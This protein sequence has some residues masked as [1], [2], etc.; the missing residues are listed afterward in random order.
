MTFD[1][2]NGCEHL[3]QRVIRFR[4]GPLARAPADSRPPG[5][6]Y[7]VAGQGELQLD[8]KRYPLGPR[9]ASSSPPAKAYAVENPGPEPSSSCQSPPTAELA[10]DGERRKVTVRFDDQAELHGV[11]RAHLPLP[12]QRGRGLRRRDPVRRDR[13]AE[14]GAHAQP[15]VRRGRATSS[16]ARESP[17]WEAGRRRL[18]RARASTCR[19]TRVHCIENSGPGRDADSRGLPPVRQPGES[20][21]YEDNK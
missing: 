21:A 15:P 3:E 20:R 16:R 4:S 17:T 1:A 19:R 5:G 12:D 18:R 13:P 6:P 7:V 14:Q 11:D 10:V 8:G 2:A 9:R